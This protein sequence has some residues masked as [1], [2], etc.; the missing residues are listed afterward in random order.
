[1][2]SNQSWTIS[3]GAETYCIDNC[4]SEFLDKVKLS[5]WSDD[6]YSVCLSSVIRTVDEVV[7]TVV[8]IN[9]VHTSPSSSIALFDVV[10]SF[11]VSENNSFDAEIMHG[12]R[13]FKFEYNRHADTM[14]WMTDSA[15]GGDYAVV[16]WPADAFADAVSPPPPPPSYRVVNGMAKYMFDGG[17]V[18][19]PLDTKDGFEPE[20]YDVSVPLHHLLLHM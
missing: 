14:R 6:S 5:N 1:M 4:A 18:I 7:D 16:M 9:S 15:A 20:A 19:A 3:T 2:S 11:D 12:K 17:Y 10:L 8:Y 13:S